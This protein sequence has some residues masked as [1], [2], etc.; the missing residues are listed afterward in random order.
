MDKCKIS[1]VEN[2]EKLNQKGKNR[3]VSHNKI[4]FAK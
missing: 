3:I 4:I 2:G 1:E